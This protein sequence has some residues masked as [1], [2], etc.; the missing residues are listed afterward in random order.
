MVYE[1]IARTSDVRPHL[2]YL[3]TP[4]PQWEL[5]DLSADPMELHNVADEPSYAPILTTLQADILAWQTA[6][7]DDWLIKRV[8][9]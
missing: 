6:T 5:F 1:I 4:R 9:E 2:S 7:A 8:H 3:H